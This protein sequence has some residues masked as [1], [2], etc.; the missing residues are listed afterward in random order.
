MTDL[1]TNTIS[2]SIKETPRNAL[3]MGREKTVIAERKED[4]L[5][6]EVGIRPRNFYD[7]PD[8]TTLAENRNTSSNLQAPPMEGYEQRWINKNKDNGSHLNRMLQKGGWNL[9]DPRTVSETA[10]LITSKWGEYNVITAGN[11]L[12]L[13][14]MRKDF[15]EH[16]QRKQ[17]EEQYQRTMDTSNLGKDLYGASSRDQ[18]RG[19]A[20]IYKP[21]FN[22]T[23]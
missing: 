18:Q 17:H 12:V 21:E 11:E 2:G 9:R 13:C 1:D 16:Q 22:S 4:T 20:S 8:Y 19:H 7:D 6:K 23:Q 15:Y 14:C 5:T 3:R 10:G